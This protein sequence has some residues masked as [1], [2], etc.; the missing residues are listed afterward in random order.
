[1]TSSFHS[2]MPFLSSPNSSGARFG[3]VMVFQVS[4]FT[5]RGFGSDQRYL[6]ILERIA[7]ED[8]LCMATVNNNNQQFLLKYA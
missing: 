4:V 6:F 8:P 7:L 1:M 5:S 3:I 2:V